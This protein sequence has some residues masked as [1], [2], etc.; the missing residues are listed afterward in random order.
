MNNNLYQ[1]YFPDIGGTIGFPK[2]PLMALP[3]PVTFLRTRVFQLRKEAEIAFKKLTLMEK[4]VKAQEEKLYQI[5]LNY[6]RLDRKLAQIDGRLKVCK[7]RH[8]KVVR[9]K[10][11]PVKTDTNVKVLNEAL[12]KMS[13]ADKEE[14]IKNL[15]K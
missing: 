13:A 2:K 5:K 10:I 11:G 9:V 1:T 6:H 12:S 8:G 15:L 4:F 3:S 14:L 7:P